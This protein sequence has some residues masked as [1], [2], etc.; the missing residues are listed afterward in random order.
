MKYK[1]GKYRSE[2][3]TLEKQEIVLDG[4][5]TGTFVIYRADRQICDEFLIDLDDSK[6]TIK[7]KAGKYTEL[8]TISDSDEHCE[9]V[10]DEEG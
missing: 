6:S 9:N 4:V 10:D 5:E 1:S 7:S 2:N 3:V 8:S